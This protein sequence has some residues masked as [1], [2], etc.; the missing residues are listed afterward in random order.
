MTIAPVLLDWSHK[1]IWV[2]HYWNQQATSYPGPQY[3]V[4]QIQVQMPILVIATGQIP[5]H[6]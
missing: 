5:D 6:I 4:S 1:T 3:L 2:F